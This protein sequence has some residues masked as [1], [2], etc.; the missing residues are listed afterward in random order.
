[1]HFDDKV[2]SPFLFDDTGKIFLPMMENTLPYVHVGTV[3]QLHGAPPH[4][5]FCVHATLDR[6]FPDQWIRRSRNLNPLGYFLL[7]VC[8]IPCLSVKGARC[9]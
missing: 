5:P 6:M 8:K 3:F 9:E 1:V 4:F 2:I 7:E